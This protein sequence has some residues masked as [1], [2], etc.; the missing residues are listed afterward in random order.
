MASKGQQDHN[1]PNAANT[2]SLKDPHILS[3]R[4]LHMG[5]R[6]QTFDSVYYRQ[7]GKGNAVRARFQELFR[8]PSVK[9]NTYRHESIDYD[10]E[11]RV[12]KILRGSSDDRLECVLFP[13]KLGQVSSKSRSERYWA[14]SYWWGDEKE[15]ASNEITIYY[16]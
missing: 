7:T 10:N 15:I 9:K 5:G 11:I 4:S 1:Q 16:E 3:T 2:Q 6:L 8:G 14:L 13:M 12:L